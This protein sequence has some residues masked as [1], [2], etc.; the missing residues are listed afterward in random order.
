[1]GVYYLFLAWEFGYLLSLQCEQAVI[2]RVLTVF[3]GRRRQWVGV[4]V[5]DWLL[6]SSQQQ[7]PAGRWFRL[8][9][10]AGPWEEVMS[11]RSI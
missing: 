2:H 1:M 11:L 4:V 7:G 6:G 3:P 5:S 9:I 10:V 8:L